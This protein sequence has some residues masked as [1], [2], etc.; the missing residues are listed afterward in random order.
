MQFEFKSTSMYFLYRY[1]HK[2][3]P[4]PPHIFKTTWRN[5]RFHQYLT[6]LPATPIE[7]RPKTRHLNLE[8]IQM[9]WN[10]DMFTIVFPPK[11][12]L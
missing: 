8:A 7:Y 4:N 6:L 10:A 1:V 12:M 3:D 2:G 5:E 9:I 11:K